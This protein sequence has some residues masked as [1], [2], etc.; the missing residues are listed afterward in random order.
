MNAAVMN[1][2]IPLHQ[3]FSNHKPTLY[4]C[5]VLCAVAS[6]PSEVDGN[7][8]FGCRHILLPE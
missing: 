6:S 4:V 8:V 1:I 7:R 2:D 3:P 5:T